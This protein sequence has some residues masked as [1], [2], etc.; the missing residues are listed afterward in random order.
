MEQK[1]Q[2]DKK[3]IVARFIAMLN[4][5]SGEVEKKEKK[6]HGKHVKQHQKNLEKF[7]A[8]KLGPGDDVK[9]LQSGVVG[10]ILEQKGDKYLISLNGN[11]TALVA[12][13]QFISASA[14]LGNKPKR[15]KRPK[16]FQGKKEQ[17]KPHD[18]KESSQTEK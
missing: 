4:Q 11:M 13:D 7:L 1:T 12:R 5:R 17:K 15:K 8:E 9:L 18:S 16:S 10:R 14:R 2:K 6:D 3:E